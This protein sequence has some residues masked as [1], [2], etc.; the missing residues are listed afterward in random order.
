MRSANI[1]SGTLFQIK[2]IDRNECTYELF[3]QCRFNLTALNKKQ[4]LEM[5]IACK[6]KGYTARKFKKAKINTLLQGIILIK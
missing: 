6:E 2:S 5:N 1:K 3:K 4:N